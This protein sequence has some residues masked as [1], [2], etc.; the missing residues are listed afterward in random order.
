MYLVRLGDRVSTTKHAL[1]DPFYL[2]E[3]RHGLAE[4]VERGA[5]VSRGWTTIVN[6]Q[7]WAFDNNTARD[8]G[9]DKSE[10]L[11]V[12]RTGTGPRI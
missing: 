8:A 12:R 4:I 3:R 1:R 11:T 9:G 10:A 2:L 5:V 7:D 6:A